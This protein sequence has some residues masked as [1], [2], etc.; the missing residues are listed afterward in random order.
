MTEPLTPPPVDSKQQEE[1]MNMWSALG[2]VWEIGYIIAVPAFIFG[3]GGAHIDARYGT[4][5][6]FILLGFVLSLTLSGTVIY[7]RMKRILS[8]L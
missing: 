3:F 6:L 1:M 2:L 7:R 8:R 5:P 4:T